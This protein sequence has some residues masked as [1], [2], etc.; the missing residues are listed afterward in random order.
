MIIANSQV[1]AM[2]SVGWTAWRQRHADAL[3]SLLPEIAASEGD[4]WIDLV[5]TVLRH[6][7]MAGL[8]GFEEVRAFGYASLTLGIGFEGR[9]DLPGLDRA[10]EKTGAARAAALW[11]VCAD[12]SH[13]PEAV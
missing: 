5:D 8:T 6:A 11:Q 2:R 4:G 3:E 7:D 10:M 12:A 1:T 13:D 9:E